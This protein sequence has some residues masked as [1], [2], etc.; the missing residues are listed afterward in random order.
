[1]RSYL[2]KNKTEEVNN[3]SSGGAFKKIVS[4]IGIDDNT[5]VYGA[6]WNN[7]LD[8]IH[9]NSKHTENLQ[10]FSE[11]KYARS[12]MGDTLN[13]VALQ[14]SRG[15]TVIFS[16]T[17]C[18]VAGLRQFL[19]VRGIDTDNLYLIDIICHGTPSPIILKDWIKS[20]E[21]KY[22]HIITGISFR[23]KEVGWLGYPTKVIFDD[24]K[25]IT[26]TYKSQ[27]FI[28]LF[29]SHV[30]MGPS[31]YECPFSNLDRK[32]DFTIGDFWGVEKSFPE[33]VPGKGISL[34]LFNTEKGI[35][36]LK[37]MEKSINCDEILFECPTE[38][39]LQ[40]QHN[41]NKPTEKPVERDNF[42]KDYKENGYDYVVKKYC[43]SNKIDK[44]KFDIKLLLSKLNLYKKVF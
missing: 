24:G 19:N 41:L 39:F 3:S 33:I 15:K 40:Y 21:K 34:I 23:D 8:V 4:C 6:I 17:P 18:Q 14:L 27:E 7:K 37:I 20:I 31:C 22:K 35:D 32:S 28:R 25:V 11:S 5:I 13:D 43:I 12:K 36:I 26:H 1:M 9:S 16:G 38:S 29:F 10:C 44:L 42:W 30:I 2:Y